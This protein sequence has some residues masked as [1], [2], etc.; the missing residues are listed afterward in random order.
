LINTSNV[1]FSPDFPL[2]KLFEITDK[3]PKSEANRYDDR[4]VMIIKDATI[5]AG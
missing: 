5:L 4:C 1:T 3:S 2:N